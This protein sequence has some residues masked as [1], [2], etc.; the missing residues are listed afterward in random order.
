VAE[1][2]VQML[3][4]IM[5]PLQAGILPGKEAKATELL[6]APEDQ[7]PLVEAEQNIKLLPRLARA[8]AEQEV[9]VILLRALVKMV[10]TMGAVAVAA[11]NQQEVG[12]LAVQV[13]M[14]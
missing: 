7:M 13:S 5:E 11:V 4:E 10:E 2:L 9:V 8:A 6:A 1:L 12:F 3:P 14:D